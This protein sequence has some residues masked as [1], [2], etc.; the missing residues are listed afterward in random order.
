MIDV[1]GD[2]PTLVVLKR[3]LSDWGLYHCEEF[4]FG[5]GQKVSVSS[6]F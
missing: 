2:F 5:D 4:N 6:K 3:D 1:V